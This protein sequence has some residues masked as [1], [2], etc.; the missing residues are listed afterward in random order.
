MM[1][2]WTG[3]DTHA[4]TRPRDDFWGQV[5]RTVHGRHATEAQVGMIVG[6]A[7]DL[8]ALEVGDRLLDLGCGNGALSRPLFDRCAGGVG[9]MSPKT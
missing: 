4:G 3:Y 6:A 5:R 2:T 9:W 1:D 7:A 8:L